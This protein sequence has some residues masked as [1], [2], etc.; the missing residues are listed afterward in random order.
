MH[1]AIVVDTVSA[2]LTQA[3]LGDQFRADFEKSVAAVYAAGV[4]TSQTVVKSEP[5]TAEEIAA[6]RAYAQTV[7]K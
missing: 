1:P 5:L 2:I 4:A 7:A 3:K 6:F